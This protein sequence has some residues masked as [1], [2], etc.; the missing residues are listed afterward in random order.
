MKKG[1]SNTKESDIKIMSLD[2]LEI[3]S[4]DPNMTLLNLK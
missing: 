3:I 1:Y 2:V 4:N